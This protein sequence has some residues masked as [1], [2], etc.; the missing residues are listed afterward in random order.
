MSTTRFVSTIPGD[1]WLLPATIVLPL[2]MVA[3]IVQFVAPGPISTTVIEI[4]IR[5]VAAVAI[6]MFSGNSGIISYGHVAFMGIGAYASAWQTCCVAMKPITMHGLPD[7]LKTANFP[8][9]PAAIAA[10]GLAAVVALVAA[11]VIMRLNSIAA[12]VATF[13][14]LFIFQSVYGHWD[15]VTMGVS[16]V[17]GLPQYITPVYAWVWVALTVT[18]AY[19]LQ[20][21]SIGLM[22]QASRDEHTAARACGAHI[23]KFRVIAF[24]TSAFFAGSAGVMLGH[25]LGTIS[26]ATYHLDLTFMLLA[27]IVVGGLR[28][29][30]GAVAGVIMV[31]VIME[32]L[33]LL[34]VGFSFGQVSLSLPGGAVQIGVAITMIA[35]LTFKRDGITG[36]R[37][38]DVERLLRGAVGRKEAELSGAGTKANPAAR[39]GV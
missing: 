15:S 21:S 34:Q 37:E 5:I 4:Y 25:L 14:L 10:G 36:G 11:L 33:K 23:L 35:I 24:S 22:L 39:M 38:F 31:S 12:A 27:M 8:V 6:Y 30:S 32:I 17:I 19:M 7:F 18:V 2:G 26:V 28:S 1:T 16:T 13:A 3:A 20:N 29:L 9:I